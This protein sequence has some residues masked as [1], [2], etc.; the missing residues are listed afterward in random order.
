MDSVRIVENSRCAVLCVHG[1]LGHPGF[2][3]FLLP[4]VPRDWSV[5]NI[6]LKGHGGSVK[7]FSAASMD[8][9][10][11]QVA[12]AVAKLRGTH[13]K[14]LIVAHS[15]G[16]LFAVREAVAGNVDALFLMNT[17]LKIRVTRRLLST[18]L[19]V[20][21]GNIKKEDRWTQAALEAYGIEQDVNLL[22]YL[23]WVPRYLELFAEIRS[24]RKIISR[25][26]VRTQVYLSAH[27]EMVSPA[28]AKLFKECHSVKVKV[29]PTSGHYYYSDSDTRM[30][31]DDF[32]Q[33]V[34]SVQ[35]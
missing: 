30:L 22:H 29:L 24:V 10:K 16:T 9:W 32:R 15:M 17:P 20:L 23:G 26:T 33:F 27:D 7:D 1:I 28:S 19:K 18:P 13:E 11:L 25:L 31:Q 12:E 4:L 3:D 21:S 6:L 2:F 35:V 5:T 34:A 8:E 14:V